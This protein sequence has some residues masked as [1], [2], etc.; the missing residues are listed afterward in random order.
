MAF[1]A[2]RALPPPWQADYT[3]NP[4]LATGAG[5]CLAVACFGV[6]VDTIEHERAGN[7]PARDQGR[8]WRGRNGDHIF[9]A[10]RRPSWRYRVSSARVRLKWISTGS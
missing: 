5:V 9:R 7:T 3:V 1:A 6:F 4:G 10:A 2:S 8:R